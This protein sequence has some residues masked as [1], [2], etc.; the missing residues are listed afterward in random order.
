[1]TSDGSYLERATEA[2]EE[3]VLRRE[4]I[5]TPGLQPE[6]IGVLSELLLRDPGRPSTAAAV[7]KDFQALGWK[8]G[9]ERYAGIE[10]RL[11]KAGH[12]ARIPA[13]DVAEG[14]PTWITRVYRNPA[15][16]Q[17][18]VDLGISASLQV[19]D[20]M[21]ETSTPDDEHGPE[22][23]ETRVSPGQSR[24]AENP[25]SGAEVRKT[26][27]PE[28]RV[29]P[30]QSRNAENP[31]SG[32]HP[33]HPPEEE[34]SSSPYPLTRTTGPLPS[35]REEGREFAPEEIA[36]AQ[37]FLQR[38]QRWQAG[39][40][41]ARKCAPRLLRAMRTQGWPMLTAMDAAQRLVLEGEIFK[42]TGGA[43]SWVKCLPGWVDDLCLY[44]MPTAPATG[45]A[46]GT[47]PQ[48]VTE[49]RAACP[50]CDQ[51]GWALD[52]DDD[53][54]NRR[55]THPGLAANSAEEQQ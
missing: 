35:Q 46:G 41:T 9:R 4:L 7:R 48:A 43:T 25:Q 1:M 32:G 13:Y 33:P 19:S 38:M 51:Y 44:R 21:R 26:R 16:N 27:N 55:C 10:A 52:D 40:A 6:D 37:D 18:Y 22:V 30:G 14:R 20:E 53:K 24:N 45:P 31:Q 28:T 29:S 11:T 47:A 17:Q 34:D 42:N 15:N 39:L 50:D 54:P 36:A 5:R 12:L 49:L 2:P 3:V 8:M 23:R